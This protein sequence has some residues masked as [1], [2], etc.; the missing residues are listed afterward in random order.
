MKNIRKYETGFDKWELKRN[1][2]EVLPPK[3]EETRKCVFTGREREINDICRLVKTPKGIFICGMFGTG[4][5]ML[6]MEALSRLEEANFTKVYASYD[7]HD[8]FRKTVLK[9]LAKT[10][11]QRGNTYAKKVYDVL[12]MGNKIEETEKERG[13][14]F[15]IA[16]GKMKWIERATLKIENPRDYIEKLI[17]SEIEEG[18][19]VV[20]AV[21]DL[22]RRADI[23]SIQEI[24]D[25]TRDILRFGSSLILMGQ[26]IGVT[27]DIRTSS[28]CIM[29]EILLDTLSEKE[30]IEMMIKYLNTARSEDKGTYPFSKNV[31]EK[32]ANNI[33]EWKLTPRL[34][35]FACFN[36]LEIASHDLLDE[37]DDGVLEKYWQ[38]MADKILGQIEELDKKY[39][40]IIYKEGGFSEDSDNVI[41]MIGGEFAGY[42]EVRGILAKLA[43]KDVLIERQDETKKQFIVNPIL[44]G[45]IDKI[46]KKDDES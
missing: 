12:T 10:I 3:D 24:I 15:G 37:I 40:E 6:V 31:A 9:N 1:P 41:K 14:N 34:F 23:A 19:T 27:R 44:K 32:I 38:K 42:A 29:H 4:K 46:S 39:L 25:D 13:M 18:R 36:L 45:T 26:P 17:E 20:I 8:G 33:V 16:D 28:G 11:S 5:T 43:Q 21:D 7:A 35:N 22:E 30:L 2:F